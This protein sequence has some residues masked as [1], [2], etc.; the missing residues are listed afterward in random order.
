[1]FERFTDSARRVIVLAQEEA[2][3]LGHDYIGAEHLLLGVL[4]VREEKGGAPLGGLVLADVRERVRELAPPAGREPMDHIPFA[5]AAKRALERSLREALN[6]QHNYIADG[7]VLLGVLAAENG[8]VEQVLATAGADI[9]RLREDALTAAVVSTEQRGFPPAT[10]EARLRELETRVD[11]LTGQVT[12]MRR[13][14][15]EGA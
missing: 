11:R 6:A 14:M 13:R 15:D 2:R 9:D 4:A 1:V 12:E 7:H 3:G 8:T 5:A 10:S